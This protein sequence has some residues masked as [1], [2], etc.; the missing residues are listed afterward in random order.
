[1]R[2]KIFQTIDSCLPRSVARLPYDVALLVIRALLRPGLS[3]QVWN[4][5]STRT[6]SFV[7]GVSDLD[8]TIVALHD[9]SY[10]FLRYFLGVMKKC[11]IFLGET[12]LYQEQ[13]LKR[14]LPRMNPYELDRDPVLKSYAGFIKPKSDVEKFIFTQRMLFSDIHTLIHLPETRQSKW[15]NH[16][17]LI[18]FASPEF[19]DAAFVLKVLKQLSGNDE[20]ISQ[21]IDNWVRLIQG[22]AFDIFQADLGEGFKILAPHCYLWFENRDNSEFLKKLTPFQKDLI[23]SQ[24]DW[25]FWGL[26]SQRYLVWGDSPLRHMER[27]TRVVELLSSK[28]AATDYQREIQLTFG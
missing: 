28:E 11:F 24:I 1:M 15:K 3:C 23:L 21:A 22:P 27:F 7:M 6:G 18:G 10:E 17:S 20:L 14:I 13:D 12:A 9:V 19:I 5:N 8:L 4:R 2:K 16:F 25:E 26:Y